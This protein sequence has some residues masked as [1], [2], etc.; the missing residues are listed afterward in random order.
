MFDSHRIVI[1]RLL[2]MLVLVMMMDIITL[3]QE[4]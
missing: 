2:N 4:G 1:L 3:L